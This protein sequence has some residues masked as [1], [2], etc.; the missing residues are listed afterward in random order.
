MKAI[1]VLLIGNSIDDIKF[2]LFDEEVTDKEFQA[3]NEV[4]KQEET[5]KL[6]T[7]FTDKMVLQ[8]DM[9][10]RIFGTGDGEVT[11]RF[12]GETVSGK[13]ESG[14]WHLNHLLCFK[15]SY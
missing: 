15:C 8:R 3:V 14:K 13:S 12:L 2:N 1:I 9:P 4:V 7:I 11:V 5:M 10:I 6:A